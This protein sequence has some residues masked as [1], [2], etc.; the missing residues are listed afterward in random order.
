M[1]LKGLHTCI[2]MNIVICICVSY[3]IYIY[4]YM[5]RSLDLTYIK[6]VMFKLMCHIFIKFYK[7]IDIF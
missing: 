1:N 4:T 5:Y 2:H 7:L 6:L 3:T